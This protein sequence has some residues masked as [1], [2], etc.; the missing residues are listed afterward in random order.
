MKYAD[1]ST[2]PFKMQK[3]YFRQVLD[4]LETLFSSAANFV[5]F[6]HTSWIFFSK[7]K[8]FSS[9]SRYNP[10][11]ELDEIL[12][13]LAE[14]PT[15]TFDVAELALALATDEYP[16]LDINEHLERIDGLAET[17]APKIALADSLEDKVLSLTEFLF[18]DEKYKGNRPQYYDPRNC[19]F[20]EVL[21]RRMG[22]PITLSILAI[23]VGE[24]AG[25]DVV[26]VSLPG[27][28]VAKAMD[29]ETEVIFDPFHGGRILTPEMCEGLVTAVTG[30]EFEA[31]TEALQP[32]PPGFIVHRILNNL[33]SIYLRQPDY[34][35]GAR[36]MERLLQLDPGDPMQ[37]RDLGVTL[38]HAGRHG[39]AMPHLKAYLD[40]QPLAEDFGDV[41]N[42]LK[43]ARKE[44]AK[45]N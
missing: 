21:D 36:V 44:I 2:Y 40:A 42:F 31:T 10:N 15:A 25:L 3:P 32:C 6:G 11:M 13:T 35:R 24:R 23:A 26:G 18:D 14:D 39:R 22:M 19:Y 12:S 20:N 1:I 9:I 33:K 28:F 43:K 4:Y 7:G 41:E 27:H 17:V 5:I 8:C 34:T 45:W 29:G 37:R 30:G 16:H 38:V